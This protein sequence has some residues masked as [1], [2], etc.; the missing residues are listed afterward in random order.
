MSFGLYYDSRGGPAPFNSATHLS[1]EMRAM[2]I[3]AESRPDSSRSA[4]SFWQLLIAVECAGVLSS[5][6]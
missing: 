1:T 4:T 6:R 2:C 5:K 3:L